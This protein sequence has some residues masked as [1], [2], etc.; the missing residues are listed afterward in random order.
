MRIFF[1]NDCNIYIHIWTKCAQ[2]FLIFYGKRKTKNEMVNMKHLLWKMMVI[3]VKSSN[4]RYKLKKKF[5]RNERGREM[6]KIF[7]TKI[8]CKSCRVGGFTIRVLILNLRFRIVFCFTCCISFLN[9]PFCISELMLF[10]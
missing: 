10:I 3:Y 4:K 6:W 9:L 5:R 8:F 2:F 1:G 7:R